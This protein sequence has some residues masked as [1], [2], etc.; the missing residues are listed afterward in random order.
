MPYIHLLAIGLSQS[1]G[2]SEL[3]PHSPSQTIITSVFQSH[4]TI[5]ISFLRFISPPRFY[6]KTTS[7]QS[8]YFNSFSLLYLIDFFDCV[9]SLQYVEND[10][11]E[12]VFSFQRIMLEFRSI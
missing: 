2:H 3:F 10:Y 4:P 12:P 9:H 7:F 1:S 8:T 11:L 5:T 6:S